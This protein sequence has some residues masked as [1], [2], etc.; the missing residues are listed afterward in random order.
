MVKSPLVMPNFNVGLSLLLMPVSVQR[1]QSF[2]EG[3]R[4]TM[5]VGHSLMGMAFATLAL[6]ENLCQIVF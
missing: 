2:P 3:G 5:Q 4:L 6:V 1:A